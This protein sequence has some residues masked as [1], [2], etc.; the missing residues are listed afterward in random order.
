MKSQEQQPDAF[1]FTSKILLLLNVPMVFATFGFGVSS[2][3]VSHKYEAYGTLGSCNISTFNSI[4]IA[5]AVLDLLFGAVLCTLMTYG[6]ASTDNHKL[7]RMLKRIVSTLRGAHSL[8]FSLALMMTL[9]YFLFTSSCKTSFDEF[10]LDV[11]YFVIVYWSC[12]GFSVICSIFCF[13]I[14]K[15]SGRRRQELEQ[16]EE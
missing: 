12:L 10:Y 14:V 4:F 9:T 16:H 15:I 3:N 8:I 6:A 5:N 1:T 11:Y 13:I 7:D 2:I